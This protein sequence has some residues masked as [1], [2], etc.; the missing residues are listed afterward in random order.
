[1]YF[2]LGQVG[3]SPVMSMASF[4]PEIQ[5]QMRK[6]GFPEFQAGQFMQL[7]FSNDGTEAEALDSH[8]L[9]IFMN[10]AQTLCFVL[11]ADSLTLQTTAYETHGTFIP[12]VIRGFD[13]VRSVVG[14]GFV[15]RVGLRY[16]DAIQPEAAENVN[17]YLV[18]G[19]HGV[20]VADR[21]VAGGTELIFDRE[22]P[23][24][25]THSR[26]VVKVHRA[27]GSIGFPLGLE[28]A[29]LVLQPRFSAWGPADHAVI[30]TDHYVQQTIAVGEAQLRPVFE[31]LHESVAEVFRACASGHAHRIWAGEVETS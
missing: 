22:L 19:L 18:E 23:R 25:G 30:D 13:L 31:D 16:L 4:V 24:W 12:E 2:A 28:P 11:S 21:L 14:M 15:K 10:E 7:R 8:P 3:F 29:G 27:N 1:V 17:D 20:E 26:V 9:W 6:T 5:E